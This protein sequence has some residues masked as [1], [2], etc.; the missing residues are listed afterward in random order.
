VPFLKSVHVDTSVV[1]EY[2]QLCYGSGTTK[3]M[4]LIAAPAPEHNLSREKATKKLQLRLQLWSTIYP[5]KKL[6]KIAAQAP[7][8][9]CGSNGSG[10]A[11]LNFVQL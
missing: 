4:K 1:L 2:I 9:C 11:T 5:E 6:Q 8:K 3:M 7:A 10:S